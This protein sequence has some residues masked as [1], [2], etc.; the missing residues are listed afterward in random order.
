MDQSAVK[1]ADMDVSF[2]QWYLDETAEM[3]HKKKALRYEERE[4]EKERRKLE[5]EKREFSCKVHAE[6]HRMEKEKQLFAMK[7]KILEEELRKLA[8]EKAQVEKQ[9]RFYDY[10][11]QHEAEAI[12][13]TETKV[14]RGDMFFIG[15]ESEQSLKK[16][17][18]DL[19]KIYHPDNP[20]GDT[21]TILEINR[22]YDRLQKI[23]H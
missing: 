21:S 8:D 4:I 6:E 16:R 7:W 22:E 13:E 2:G 5:R 10:V 3:E 23:Y 1:T 14:V 17:Y 12:E 18:R 9:R 11:A 15:V 19:I 20:T